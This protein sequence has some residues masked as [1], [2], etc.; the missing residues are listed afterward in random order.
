MIIFMKKIPEK[1]T[2]FLKSTGEVTPAFSNALERVLLKYSD[3]SRFLAD[4]LSKP[5][6]DYIIKEAHIIGSILSGVDDSD[7]DIMLIAN[8]IDQN[9][10]SLFKNFLSQAFFNNRPKIGAIDVFVRPYDAFPERPSYEVTS[11]VRKVLDKYNHLIKLSD[12]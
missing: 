11:Q 5:R 6:E 12:I 2:R 10:Y 9:D 8:K 4:R 7:L 1:S 3:L